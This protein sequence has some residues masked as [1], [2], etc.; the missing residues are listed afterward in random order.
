MVQPGRASRLE[1][2]HGHDLG[3]LVMGRLGKAIE[4]LFTRHKFVRRVIVLWALWLITVVVLRFVELA[5]SIDTATVTGVGTIVGI[6][7]TVLGFYIKSRELDSS[8][9]DGD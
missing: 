5:T 9:P 3:N 6:L 7:S 1:A 8:D 4:A 2:P